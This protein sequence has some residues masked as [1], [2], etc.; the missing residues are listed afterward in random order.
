MSSIEQIEQKSNNENRQQRE[1]Q[2]Q[3]LQSN[4][5]ALPVDP[6]QGDKATAIRFLLTARP[7]MRS[8]YFAFV[9]LFIGMFLWYTIIPLQT[10][11]RDSLDGFDT[12]QIW[13]SNMAN[14]IG[15]FIGRLVAGPLCDRYGAKRP[16]VF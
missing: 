10:E 5:F 14:V 6:E 16:M 15:C 7:H 11:I 8:F 2:E 1:Q 13:T 12:K 9:C 4:N 3:K